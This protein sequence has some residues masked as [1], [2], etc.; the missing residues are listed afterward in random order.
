[1]KCLNNFSTSR[2][3]TSFKHIDEAPEQ[4]RLTELLNISTSN[5]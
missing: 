5:A 4:F 1:M 3:Q 2:Q